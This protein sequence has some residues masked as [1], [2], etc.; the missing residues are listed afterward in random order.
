MIRDAEIK[1]F[2]AVLALNE[3]SER[4]LSPMVAT[5]LSQLHER[6]AYHRVVE[7]DATITAFLLAFREGTD[8]DSPNYRWFSE[9]YESFLYIDRVVVSVLQ[10]GRRFG[11]ALYDDLF[12]FAKRFAITTVTCEFDIHPI[13]EAS[14]RFH[15]KFGFREVGTQWVANGKKQVSLQ[16]MT[17]VLQ[18]NHTMERTR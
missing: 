8:Y 16:E 17:Q 6:A 1:D 14:K 11:A 18:P 12:K 13:N 3:E 4:F 10:Q 9:R 2:P 15:S 5:R 7:V